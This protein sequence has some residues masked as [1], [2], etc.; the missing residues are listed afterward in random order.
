L[1]LEAFQQPTK[2]GRIITMEKMELTGK[3]VEALDKT[4]KKLASRLEETNTWDSADLQ[5]VE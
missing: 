2:K 4:I 3:L 1:E 5:F